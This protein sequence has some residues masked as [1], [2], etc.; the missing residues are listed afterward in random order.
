MTTDIHIIS[1]EKVKENDKRRGYCARFYF[2]S[3]YWR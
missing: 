1:I 2:N 3:S